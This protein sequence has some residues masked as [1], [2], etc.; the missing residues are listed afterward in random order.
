MLVLSRKTDEAIII[1]ELGIRIVVVQIRGTASVKIGIEAD[2]R[3]TVLREE[4]KPEDTALQPQD[5]VAHGDIVD[6][7]AGH[8]S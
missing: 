4:L 7:S 5:S 8:V 6:G 2:R 1:P 3:Y